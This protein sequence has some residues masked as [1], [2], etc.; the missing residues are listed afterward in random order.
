MKTT[1]K[2]PPLLIWCLCVYQLILCRRKTLKLATE[3][4][5]SSGN[6]LLMWEVASFSH[7][8]TYNLVLDGY[9]D[10]KLGWKSFKSG[11]L[12]RNARASVISWNNY[13][14]KLYI[15][16]SQSRYLQQDHHQSPNFLLQKYQKSSRLECSASRT[17]TEG[18]AESK[19]SNRALNYQTEPADPLF[20]LAQGNFFFKLR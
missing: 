3:D 5:N 4:M 10:L 14:Q 16:R 1:V 20:R 13:H 6:C 15:A 12:V 18:A 2:Y 17:D 7:K 19:E 11:Y 9:R 8:L